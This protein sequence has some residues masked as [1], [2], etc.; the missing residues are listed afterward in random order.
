M[1]IYLEITETLDWEKLFFNL[2]QKMN[3]E[4]HLLP[5]IPQNLF[6]QFKNGLSAIAVIGEEI[7]GHVTI[8]NIADSWYEIGSTYTDPTYRGRHINFNL[9]EKLLEKHARK[10]I[11]ETTTN[12]ISIHVGEKLG[13][14]AVKRKSLPTETFQG[15]CICSFKKTESPN[16]LASC[17]LAWD[18]DNW[19]SFSDWIIPCH[20][21]VTSETFSRNR[22]LAKIESFK[23]ST[24]RALVT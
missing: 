14:I 9:Y 20:V 1:K 16:P 21:R 2:A 6:S 11:L 12:Q 13:F 24:A 5:Q 15:T 7:V 10:N 3:I 19:Q 22:D 18:G 17:K 23:N 4:K 8:W